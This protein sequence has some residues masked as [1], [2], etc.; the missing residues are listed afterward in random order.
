MSPSRSA[1]TI[2]GSCSGWRARKCP[3]TPIMRMSCSTRAWSSFVGRA[4]GRARYCPGAARSGQSSSGGPDLGGQ[5]QERMA[6]LARA[7]D[8]DPS[9]EPL[10][11]QL[12]PL[13][14]SVN[15]HAEAAAYYG[16]C[17]TELARWVGRSVS[18]EL[19]ALART[20]RSR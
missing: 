2:L 20:I 10:Y 18:A 17:R 14:V 19:Q 5:C 1:H 16:R 4:I 11:Q 15:R 3:S 13:L 8:V 12:I 7:I 9:A 6:E